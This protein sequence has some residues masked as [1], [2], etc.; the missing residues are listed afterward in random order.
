MASGALVLIWSLWTYGL[1]K[2]ARIVRRKGLDKDGGAA[3]KAEVAGDIPPRAQRYLCTAPQ[4]GKPVPG[5]AG[6]FTPGG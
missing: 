6:G 4:K 1:S 3:T 5:G 2:S